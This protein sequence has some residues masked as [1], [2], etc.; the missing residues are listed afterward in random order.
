MFFSN[1]YIEELIDKIDILSVVR[2]RVKLEKKGTK[3][4][5]L[6]PFHSE[7]TP[8]FTVDVKRN[9]YHCFGC[10]AGGSI[11]D[12][13]RQTRGL[14]FVDT[15][16]TLASEYG[17]A[18]P[19]QKNLPRDSLRQRLYEINSLAVD[20][21]SKQ[22]NSTNGIS[23]T[24]YLTNRGIS[25]ETVKIFNIG[26]CPNRPND[27]YKYLAAQK[28]SNKEMKDAGLVVEYEKN[29]YDRFKDRIIFPIYNER[30]KIIG[31]GGRLIAPSANAPKYL[32]SPETLLFKKG[33][34]LYAENLALASLTKNKSLVIVEGYMDVISLYQAGIKNVVATLGTA[35]TTDHI[36]KIWRYCP[37]PTICLDGDKAGLLAMERCA[38]L[39]LP[40]LKPGYYVQFVKLPENNDPDDTIKNFGTDYTQKLLDNPISLSEALLQTESKKIKSHTPEQKALLQKNLFDLANQIADN[41]VKSHFRRYF[42]EQLWLKNNYNKATNKLPSKINMIAVKNLSAL[43]RAQ[44]SLIA[45]VIEKP[46]LLKKPDVFTNLVGLVPVE[47]LANDLIHNIETI[48]NELHDISDEEFPTKFTDRLKETT[49]SSKLT[50]LCGP[51]SYFIDKISLKDENILLHLWQDAF[52]NYNLELLRN[53]YREKIQNS[54]ENSLQLAHNIKSQINQLELEILNRKNYL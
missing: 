5:G 11:I 27:L 33:Q 51:Q 30:K 53:E 54:D 25:Q 47:A 49:D 37:T 14:N 31:F 3:Y 10:H 8:S 41:A 13:V 1:E 12:F 2:Q 7:K 44:L 26:Y 24:K 16:T 9:L 39:V 34:S 46:I 32:N 22:L 21:F 6:C 18:L 19:A 45:L 4:L 43:E 38:K 40:I 35:I 52:N 17:I 36:Q 42:N 48:Y 15:I 29:T 50:Y 20:W 23:A 28:V